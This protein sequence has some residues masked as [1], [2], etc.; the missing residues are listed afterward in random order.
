MYQNNFGFYIP[1]YFDGDFEDTSGYKVESYERNDTSTA[2]YAVKEN[3]SYTINTGGLSIFHKD[4]VNEVANSIDCYF[5]NDGKYLR[6]N[7]DI[8]KSTNLKSR[9]NN[10]SQDLMFTFTAGLPFLNLNVNGSIT[11]QEAGIITLNTLVY[12][13]TEDNLFYDFRLTFT[14]SFPI[15]QLFYQ[16]MFNNSGVWTQPEEFTGLTSPQEYQT[17]N[18]ENH[19]VRVFAYYAGNIVYSNILSH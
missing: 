18:Y 4:I 13:G 12:L 10:Y 15:F 5:N 9:L 16:L 17:V 7:S 3:G 2:V 14:T 11:G 8:K 19:Q 1:A 6:V